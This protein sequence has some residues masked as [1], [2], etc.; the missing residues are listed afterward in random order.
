MFEDARIAPNLRLLKDD[1]VGD[2]GNM[3]WVVMA[4]VSIVLLIACANVANLLLVRTEARQQELAVRAALGAGASRIARE[5]LFESITLGFIAG[6]V[7]LGL[8]SAALKLL[9]ASDLVH[10]P[11]SGNIRI[12]G[13]VLLFTFIVSSGLSGSFGLIPVLRYVRPRLANALRSGGR[14]M[15]QSKDRQQMRSFLVV[16]QVALA[17]VLLVTSGLHDAHVSQSA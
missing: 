14:S 9:S 17:L 13:W 6:L 2:I 11:R 16:L 1:L 5:L 3:L 7:G 10:L 8:C 4:T 12:D 15:S